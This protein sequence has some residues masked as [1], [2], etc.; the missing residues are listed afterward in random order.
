MIF[1][2]FEKMTKPKGRFIDRSLEG[3]ADFFRE[4]IVGFSKKSQLKQFS[5]FKYANDYRSS[6]TAI[7][8][9]S[10]V[11][12]VDNDKRIHRQAPGG[13]ETITLRS[14]PYLCIDEAQALIEMCGCEALIYTTPSH[15]EDHN[16]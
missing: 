1:T 2:I 11:F 10:I 8:A 14:D 13:V 3:L 5:P 6:S 7:S 16:K 12:D 4:N 15:H 9:S